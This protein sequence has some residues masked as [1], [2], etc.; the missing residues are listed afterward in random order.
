MTRSLSLAMVIPAMVLFFG[1]TQPSQPEHRESPPLAPPLTTAPTPAPMPAR[2]YLSDKF[3]VLLAGIFN[4]DTKTLLISAG[5]PEKQTFENLDSGLEA[6]EKNGYQREGLRKLRNILLFESEYEEKPDSKHSL[7]INRFDRSDVFGAFEVKESFI[8]FSLFDVDLTEHLFTKMVEDQS[9]KG[10]CEQI[11]KS[12]IKCPNG[13]I[14]CVIE[15]LKK[16]EG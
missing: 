16:K 12:C 4:R 15:K 11:S 2:D 14:Y 7:A 9:P 10:G 5:L 13:K 1:C 6:L 8:A 3:K